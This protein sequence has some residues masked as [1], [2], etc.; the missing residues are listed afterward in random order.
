[1]ASDDE[2]VLLDHAAPVDDA[3]IIEVST[4]EPDHTPVIPAR[5][6]TPPRSQRRPKMNKFN[7]TVG[8]MCLC[9][10]IVVLIAYFTGK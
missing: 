9:F 10:F 4:S 1:M 6:V 3:R 7:I 2:A 5:D 8:I